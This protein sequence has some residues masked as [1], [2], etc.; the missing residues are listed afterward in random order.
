MVDNSQDATTGTPFPLD[1]ASLHRFSSCPGHHPA[2]SQRL[3]PSLFD[4]WQR[5]RFFLQ[6]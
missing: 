2:R 3:T 6:A 4:A 5:T 1:V